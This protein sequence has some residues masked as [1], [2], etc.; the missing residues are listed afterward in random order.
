MQKSTKGLLFDQIHGTA[1]LIGVCNDAIDVGS[2]AQV[3]GIEWYGIASSLKIAVREN[4][5]LTAKYII[6]PNAYM[7]GFG[8][9]E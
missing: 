3:T 4:S 1:L 7:T 6:N 5:N 9:V 2:G 8:K